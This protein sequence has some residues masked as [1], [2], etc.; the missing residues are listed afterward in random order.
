[1]RTQEEALSQVHVVLAEG[2]GGGEG[3]LLGEEQSLPGLPI[4]DWGETEEWWGDMSGGTERCR[5]GSPQPLPMPTS[6]KKTTANS[7]F[8][9][10]IV[11]M[12]SWLYVY[13][14]T[15]QNLYIKYVHFC[16]LSIP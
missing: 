11:M 9:N 12:V 7:V 1:M 14:Q 13:V 5:T 15:C 10:N 2:R 8:K 16:I 6:P 4:P 3:D